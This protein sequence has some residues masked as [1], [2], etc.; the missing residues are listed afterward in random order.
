MILPSR[1][2]KENTDYHYLCQRGERTR[3]NWSDTNHAK[4][5]KLKFNATQRVLGVDIISPDVVV[6]VSDDREL[7]LWN[8]NTG[9]MLQSFVPGCAKPL[10][11]ISILILR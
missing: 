1:S 2:T 10:G 5:I 4:L 7:R 6:T 11:S 3:R 9:R 8:S